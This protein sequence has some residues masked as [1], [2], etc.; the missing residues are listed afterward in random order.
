MTTD[1]KLVSSNEGVIVFSQGIEENWWE[2]YRDRGR[3]RWDL[4]KV[5]LS[6]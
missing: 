1:V 5:V 2:R 4:E 3:T 6:A